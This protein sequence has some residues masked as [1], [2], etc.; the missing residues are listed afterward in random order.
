MN[1][2]LGQSNGLA[3]L[4]T[5]WRRRRTDDDDWVTPDTIRLGMRSGSFRIHYQPVV[6]AEQHRVVAIE[7]LLRWRVA[8]G[9]RAAREFVGV[10]ADNGI[11]SEIDTALI[12]N[13]CEFTR[14]LQRGG[15]ER[16]RLAVNV[17]SDDLLPGNGLF[18][19]FRDAIEEANLM[20][21]WVQVEVRE[22]DLL[23]RTD[24]VARTFSALSSL[25]VSVTIDDFEAREG[26]RIVLGLPAVRAVKIDLWHAAGDPDREARAHIA[27]RAARNANLDIGAKRLES[28]ASIQ[29]ANDLGA[30]TLQGFAFGTPMRPMEL[31]RYLTELGYGQPQP[32]RAAVGH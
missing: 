8:S 23:G 2:E 30:D 20:P 25:G 19:R 21:Q 16:L 6:D 9:V 4:G 15:L 14:E 32:Q 28:P 13:A 7:A 26:S 24:E 5:L 12:G 11:L 27:A 17:T 31:M 1:T 10:A 22:A 29:L 3:R 18:G